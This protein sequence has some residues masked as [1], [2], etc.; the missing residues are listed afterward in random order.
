MC[1]RACIIGDVIVIITLQDG[2]TALH[3]AAEH[4]HI[5]VVKELL[6]AHADMN[7]QDKVRYV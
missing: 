7:L 1:T 5:A 2:K 6:G 4:G 3:L